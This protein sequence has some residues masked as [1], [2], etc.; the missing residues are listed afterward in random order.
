MPG[1]LKRWL[2]CWRS[3]TATTRPQAAQ[4]GG[5]P[6]IHDGDVIE[7]TRT[8]PAEARLVN[9]LIRDLNE[10]NLL[11]RAPSY[12]DA[13][14]ADERL[15]HARIVASDHVVG[16]VSFVPDPKPG[17]AVEYELTGLAIHPG[18]RGFNLANVLAKAAMVY[19]LGQT[20]D[21]DREHIA[22][23][24]DGNLGPIK[25]L[26][27]VGFQ[28]RENIELP[29]GALGGALDHTILPGEDRIRG[30]TYGF[31]SGVLDRLIEDLLGFIENGGTLQHRDGKTIK[32]EFNSNFINRQALEYHRDWLRGTGS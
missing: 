26:T 23:V 2:Q 19:H 5:P 10:P 27:H 4:R 1:R 6:V 18:C 30:S 13:A 31:D 17:G 20:A 32:V 15:I 8:L 12:F 7:M 21:E 28:L 16:A 25:A 14:A 29:R 9:Q 22:H 3:G 24:L 11:A